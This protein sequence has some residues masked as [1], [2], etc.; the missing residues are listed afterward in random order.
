MPKPLQKTLRN[1]NQG[2]WKSRKSAIIGFI[3][4]G[5]RPRLHQYKSFRNSW[6]GRQDQKVPCAALLTFCILLASVREEGMEL[7]FMVYY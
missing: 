4:R 6:R 5:D 1:S 7:T 2:R 3:S